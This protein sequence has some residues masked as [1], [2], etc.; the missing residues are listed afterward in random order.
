M[1]SGGAHLIVP[2]TSASR[3]RAR[4][5]VN[6]FGVPIAPLPVCGA[7]LA[8]MRGI[9][10][11]YAGLELLDVLSLFGLYAGLVL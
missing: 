3:S 8:L 2:Y 1:K 7:H 11:V 5:T 10:L 4:I 6:I 9:L